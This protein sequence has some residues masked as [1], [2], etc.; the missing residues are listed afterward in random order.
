M[1]R[2]DYRLEDGAA[3]ITL[4]APE[5]VN[6]L[7]MEMVTELHSLVRRA[8]SDDARVVVIRGAGR[9]FCVGGDVGFFAAAEDIEHAIEDLAEVLHRTV[10]DLL[11]MNAI[12]VTAVH[13]AVAGAGVALSAVGD[14]VLAAEST[15]FTLAYTKLGLSP[16]GGSSMLSRSVGLHR[17]LHLALMNPLLSAREAHAAGLVGEVHADE[18]LD[19]AVARTVAGLLAGSRDAQVATKRLFRAAEIASPEGHLRQE[20]LAIRTCAAAPDGLEGVAAFAARRQPEFPSN[21]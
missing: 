7:D 16:D 3:Y 17:A 4:D 10:S 2:V 8:R 18:H 21:G 9:S 15:R 1:S 12:V 5:R 6:A 13:G 14:V 20:A 19:E 11:R